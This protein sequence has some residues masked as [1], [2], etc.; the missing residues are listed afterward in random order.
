[1]IKEKRLYKNL[2]LDALSRLTCISKSTLSNLENGKTRNP[3]SVF[4]YRLSMVLDIDMDIMNQH[5]YREYYRKKELCNS[6]FV[7]KKIKS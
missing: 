5:K 3:S 1:M 6:G 7:D 2:T 4:L